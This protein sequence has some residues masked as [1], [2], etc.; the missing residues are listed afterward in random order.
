[1]VRD[2]EVLSETTESREGVL[3]EAKT[4]VT[5]APKNP[6]ILIMLSSA[7]DGDAQ[8]FLVMPNLEE[9]EKLGLIEE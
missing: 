2:G 8:H 4:M 5:P 3:G 7:T 6:A 1:M 9:L